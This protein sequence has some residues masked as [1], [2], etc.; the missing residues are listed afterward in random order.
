[1]IILFTDSEAN[2]YT[3]VQYWNVKMINLVPYSERNQAIKTIEII[4]KYF[5]VYS[6]CHTMEFQY[7]MVFWMIYRTL[8]LKQIKLIV[9]FYLR[10]FITT[11]IYTCGK[12][13]EQSYAKVFT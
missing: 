2:L 8:V 7:K 1:M 3:I 9:Q 12:Q 10:L 5:N 11:G 13:V 4:I 6:F